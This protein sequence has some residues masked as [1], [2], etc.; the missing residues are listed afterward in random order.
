MVS[1][2]MSQTHISATGNRR[3]SATNERLTAENSRLR[4]RNEKL[5]RASKRQAAPF[6]KGDGTGDEKPKR[7]RKR[8]G[9][10]P[11]AAYGGR[12]HRSRPA[13]DS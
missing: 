3:L 7:E 9:R 5:A 10:K 13:R 11:G 12:A 1:L 8:A 6:S 4:E 2:L